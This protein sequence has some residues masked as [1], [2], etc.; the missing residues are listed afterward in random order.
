[1]KSAIYSSLA[2]VLAF[3]F[4]S[5]GYESPK[6]KALKA[7]ADSIVAVQRA[8]ERD[9]KEYVYVFNHLGKSAD[10][11]KEKEAGHIQQIKTKLDAAANT[12][13]NDNIAKL[14]TLL[15]SDQEEVDALKKQVRRN[16]F[17]AVELQRELE[18]ISALLEKEMA[19]TDNLQTEI[20]IKDA[21]LAALDETL[22]S[23]NAELDSLKR[24]LAEHA[25]LIDRYEDELFSGY[26]ITG[27][28]S[29]LKEKKVISKSG[30]CK[31][32][33][34]HE[35]A[36]K[37]DFTKVNILETTVIKLPDS[38]KGKILSAHPK[39]S[40]KLSMRGADK[41]IEIT[42]SADFWSITKY[43]VIQ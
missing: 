40:Y 27:S 39:A 36:N 29:E 24:Q 19:K 9:V 17:R 8:L 20:A 22:K 5:C 38:V 7:H 31:T 34:F 35:K 15:Q 30:L 33:L 6:Y 10:K 41:V 25:E 13:V 12:M 28:K 37:S 32:A 11:I 3:S 23:L 14:N 21:T 4:T 2:I 16:A 1:M 26:Y 43:L 18:Q 42:N